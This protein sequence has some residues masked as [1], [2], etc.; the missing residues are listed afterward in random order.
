MCYICSLTTTSLLSVLLLGLLRN[1]CSHI[2]HIRCTNILKSYTLKHTQMIKYHTDDKTNQKSKIELSAQNNSIHNLS[3]HTITLHTIQPILGCQSQY[4]ILHCRQVKQSTQN[5][6]V[7]MLQLVEKISVV[8]RI[9]SPFRV[10][11]CTD[12]LTIV[13]H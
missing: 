6:T 8:F 11:L 13:R 5:G 3:H 4:F 12:S 10:S 1:E 9:S 2:Q 7:S